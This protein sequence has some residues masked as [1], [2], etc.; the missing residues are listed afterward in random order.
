MLAPEASALLA[1]RVATVLMG[2]RPVLTVLR[3][4]PL[5]Q[6]RLHALY[7]QQERPRIAR[8]RQVAPPAPLARSAA[9][10]P[11]LALL[12]MLAPMLPPLECRVVRNAPLVSTSTLR[13]H[14]SVMIVELTH[15]PQAQGTQSV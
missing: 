8:A 4:N 13:P 9:Q 14:Q 2:L 3:V 15:T 7:A 10:A 1:L 12:A 5:I 11:S 6:G